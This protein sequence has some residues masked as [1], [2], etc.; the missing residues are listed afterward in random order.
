MK[1]IIN[2]EAQ[3]RAMYQQ[4]LDWKVSQE[5]QQDAYAFERSFDQFCQQMNRQMLQMATQA[6]SS[7]SKKKYIPDSAK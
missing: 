1:E 7:G 5:G 6:K 3:F 4:Y 2:E